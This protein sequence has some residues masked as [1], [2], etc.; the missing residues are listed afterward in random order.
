M[1]CHAGQVGDGH[2]L[3][4]YFTHD[5]RSP[6]ERAR[7]VDA[8]RDPG[9]ATRQ[10]NTRCLC[11]LGEE[12][13]CIRGVDRLDHAARVTNAWRDAAKTVRL[14]RAGSPAGAPAASPASTAA[15]ECGLRVHAVTDHGQHLHA[16]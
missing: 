11:H 4:L 8:G 6:T 16:A 1:T 10:R 2:P 5:T 14:R 7:S 9:R 12:I 15:T 3:A 13:A